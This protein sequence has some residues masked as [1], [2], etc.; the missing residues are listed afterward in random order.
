MRR[1]FTAWTLLKEGVQ[2]FIADNL[3]LGQKDQR[4]FETVI[5]LARAAD[6]ARRDLNN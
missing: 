2:A 5:Q 3:F 1:H 4:F 6:D